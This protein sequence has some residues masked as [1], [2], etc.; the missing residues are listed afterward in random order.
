MTIRHAGLGLLRTGLLWTGL[1]AVLA[2]GAPSEARAT[3][4]NFLD[5]GIYDVGFDPTTP[6]FPTAVDAILP[7]TGPFVKADNQ[8]LSPVQYSLDHCLLVSG[9]SACQP[10]VG[11]GL[12]YSDVVTLTLE[13]VDG[14]LPAGGIT[15]FLSGL[16]SSPAYGFDD[17]SV[18]LD[19]TNPG[20]VFTPLLH[21]TLTPGSTTYHYFGFELDSIGQSVTFRY[22]V[23]AMLAGGTPRI[24]TNALVP[25]PGTAALLAIGLAGLALRQRR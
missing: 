17:V 10:S 18:E 9:S 7:L 15:L 21:L 16:S 20:Y 8:G 11:V 2:T 4:I 25:E 24:A 1:V 19:P 13:S 5:G 6:G 14:G 22:D 12:A 3:S 23:S